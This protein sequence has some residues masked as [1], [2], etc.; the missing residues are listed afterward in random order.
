MC[1]CI[2][3]IMLKY[4]DISCCST[5]SKSK[6]ETISLIPND[7]VY[8]NRCPEKQRTRANII[9]SGQQ[10]NNRP[11]S[12]SYAEHLKNKKSITYEKK[13]P[14][15]C[16]VRDNTVMSD[17]TYDRSN[18]SGWGAGTVIST[19]DTES[20]AIEVCNLDGTCI[21]IDSVYEMVG[22][23]LRTRY[24]AMSS[25]T[26]THTIGQYLKERIDGKILD[27]NKTHYKPNNEK[28]MQQ[29]AVTSSG[30]LERLKYDT[31]TNVN[32]CDGDPTKCTGVYTGG[33]PRFT[34]SYNEATDV[35]CPQNT[36]KHRVIGG[37]P[38]NNRCTRL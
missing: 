28:F 19:H 25:G 3:Y 5:T 23:V 30:R 9:R 32:K 26:K 15:V 14:N 38:Y 18:D 12:Y 33:K 36:A 21:G 37:Y 4:K 20:E 1:I 7:S 31:I 34:G 16:T 11:Y 17:Y 10:P 24:R 2:I 22:F 27:C 8:K 29:G 13:L 6:V 35:N